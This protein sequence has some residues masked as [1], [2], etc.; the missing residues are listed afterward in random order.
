LNGNWKFDIG[1]YMKNLVFLYGTD[2]YRLQKRL[3][4]LSLP[5][6]FSRAT[7]DGSENWSTGSFAAQVQAVPFFGNTR[8]IIVKNAFSGITTD[9]VDRVLSVTGKV[10]ATTNVIFVESGKPDARTRLFK[11]LSKLSQVETFEPLGGL[12]WSKFVDE[13]ARSANLK[14]SQPARDALLFDLEGDSAQLIQ[15]VAQLQLWA[16]PPASAWPEAKLQALRAGEREITASDVAYFVPRRPEG[17]SFK[18]LGALAEKRIEGA[19]RFLYDLWHQDEAPMRVLGAIVYQYRQILWAK[20]YL[21]DGTPVRELA[22][23]LKVPPFVVGR[24]SSIASRVSWPWVKTVYGHI[25]QIDEGIK[26]GKIEQQAGIEVLV[27]NLAQFHSKPKSVE[28]VL[29]LG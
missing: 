3:K 27:Y 28:P 7:I 12:A 21:E 13:T 8:Q 18:L 22:S 9:E 29:R 14:L 10:P 23:K 24:L 2:T 1:I 19:V 11:A 25:R 20:A 4:E 5:D 6:E 17:D 16:G 26:S 15:V